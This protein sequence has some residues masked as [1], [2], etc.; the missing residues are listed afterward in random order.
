MSDDPKLDALLAIRDADGMITPEGVLARAQNPKSPLHAAFEWDD[1]KA[2]V[3]YRLEQARALVRSYK[4]KIPE[5]NVNIRRFTSIETADG[6]GYDETTRVL[7][8]PFLRRQ[9]LDRLTAELKAIQ[10]RYER[11]GEAAGII[12]QISAWLAEREAS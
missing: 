1:E 4:V 8:N 9:L 3:Q 2:A 7:D 11:I 10:S 6:R 12:G 5:L